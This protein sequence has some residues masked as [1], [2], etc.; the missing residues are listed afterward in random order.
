MGSFQL[1]LHHVISFYF[2]AK[3]QNMKLEFTRFKEKFSKMKNIYIEANDWESLFFQIA[4]KIEEK[5]VIVI[6]EF[7]YWIAKD[8]SILSEFQYIW[9][10]ILKKKNIF[11]ILT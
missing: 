3:E 8:R 1:N 2:L 10:E 9:D 4:K 5:I 11:L 6:D 7:S